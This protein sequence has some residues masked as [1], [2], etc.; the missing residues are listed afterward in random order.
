MSD[1]LKMYARKFLRLAPVYYAFWFIIWG[2]VARVGQ[3]PLW[4]I[5]DASFDECKDT[6]MYTALFVGN[7][8]PSEVKPYEGCYQYAW[9]LQVDMQI[10][11]VV[12]I[13]AIVFWK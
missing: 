9:P 7:I 8:W 10:A 3:G 2:L 11:L 6:W 12:P 4:H 1:I 5:T 13:F